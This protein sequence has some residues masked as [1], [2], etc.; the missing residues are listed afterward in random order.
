MMGGVDDDRRALSLVEYYEPASN[1]WKQVAPMNKARAGHA[2]AVWNGRLYVMGGARAYSSVEW[3]DLER[4]EWIEMEEEE[5]EEAGRLRTG[6]HG[7]AA[8]VVGLL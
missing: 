8:A 4:N 7:H 5:E 3:Y 1:E 2:A 6:R